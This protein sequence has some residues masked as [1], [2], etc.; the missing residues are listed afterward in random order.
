MQKS[1]SEAA[2]KI[3][4]TTTSRAIQGIAIFLVVVGTITIAGDLY[5]LTNIRKSSKSVR[6]QTIVS[7]ARAY[8]S[9]TVH[10]RTVVA[11]LLRVAGAT[12]PDESKLPTLA[13]I[14]DL[15]GPRPVI[16]G[17]EHCERFRNSV[18]A[19]GKYLLTAIDT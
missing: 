5:F 14:A 15:Y 19:S 9:T 8:S 17:L 2:R 6:S 11:N 16:L 4:R 7:T 3:S 12:V 18:P 10:N 13:Q 1:G